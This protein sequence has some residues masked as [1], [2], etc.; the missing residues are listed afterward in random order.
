MIN[1]SNKNLFDGI[2]ENSGFQA[3]GLNTEGNTKRIRSKNYT[4]VKENQ[5]YTIN[6]T[7]YNTTKGT[8]SIGISYYNKNDYSTARLSESGWKNLPYTF[9]TPENCKF[10]RLICKITSSS[11]DSEIIYT[12][13]N[14]VQ[15]E[16]SSTATTY[17][18]HQGKELPLD[19]PVENLF[20]GGFQQGTLRL[21]GAGDEATSNTRIRT[22]YISVIP[23]TTYTISNNNSNIYQFGVGLYKSDNSYDSNHKIESGGW[24]NFPYTFTTQSD[25]YYLRMVFKNSTDTSLSPTGDYEI[26]VENNVKANAYTPYGT[27]PIE[28]CKIGNYQD[29][30]YKSGSKWY[31]HKEIGKTIFNGSESW[32]YSSGNLVF[33][34]DVLTLSR[35]NSNLFCNRFSKVANTTTYANMNTGEIKYDG[36]GSRRIIIKYTNYTSVTDFK[37]WLASNNTKVYYPLETATDSE[38]TNT[39]LISQLNNLQ[40]VK[41]YQGTTYI[42]SDN[43]VGP[44][45]DIDYYPLSSIFYETVQVDRISGFID[46]IDAIKQA[47]YHILSIERFSCLIY[48]NNYGVELQQYIGQDFEYLKVTVQKTLEEALMQDERIISIE[49]IDVEKI[50]NETANVKLLIQ[51]NIGEIQMEV[52]VNV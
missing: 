7:E 1:T 51:A 14:K 2:L 33:Y 40:Q 13:V 44:I 21:N 45:L 41:S 27:D 6:I 20:D 49:V 34:T 11:G 29:Y 47:V 17:E 4:R 25:T 12:D 5:T 46:D 35:T 10:I 43:E 18:P 3:T 23:N 24:I 42:Y 48:D 28:L 22:G 19:L 31:L 52:N 37:T 50:D 38:I 15:L 8:I 32:S 16:Q 39:N 9:I 26:M 30:F 36:A